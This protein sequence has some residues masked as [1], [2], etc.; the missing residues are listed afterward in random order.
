MYLSFFVVS[1]LPEERAVFLFSL[2]S[3][4]THKIDSPSVKILLSSVRTTER[5]TSSKFLPSLS[6]V[7]PNIKPTSLEESGGSQP[8]YRAYG[9]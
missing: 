2:I 4:V 8:P 5:H 6:D 1:T 7:L 9:K 3:M